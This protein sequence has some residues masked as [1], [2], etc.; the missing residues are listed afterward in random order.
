MLVSCRQLFELGGVLEAG[1]QIIPAQCHAKKKL[2]TGHDAVA[3]ADAYPALGQIQL[4]PADV[5]C[6]R[7]LG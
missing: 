2:H 6:G 3:I 5:L 7:R 4:E 1:S